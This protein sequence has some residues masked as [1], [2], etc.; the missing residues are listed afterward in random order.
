MN[1]ERNPVGWFEIYVSDLPRARAFYEA[2]LGVKLEDLPSPDPA[3]E[4]AAFPMDEDK[5]G[6]CGALAKMHG[7]A[8]GPGGTL[9][10]FSCLDCAEEEARA[11]EAGGDIIKPKFPIGE[12]GFITLLTD[13]EGN[14]IGL[15][16]MK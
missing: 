16:S 6:S 15:H 1:T 14:T 3:I 9:I 4:M 11:A 7:C 8:P 5:P 10:Y 13:T 2:M 12:Y